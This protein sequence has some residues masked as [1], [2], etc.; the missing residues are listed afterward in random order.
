MANCLPSP[1]SSRSLITST[2]SKH[3]IPT[4]SCE[5]CGKLKKLHSR[6]ISLCD[7]CYARKWRRDHPEEIKAS[8]AASYARNRE[9]RQVEARANYWSHREQRLSY[10][11]AYGAAHR[12]EKSESNR[13]YRLGH[14]EELATYQQSYRLQH[15]FSITTDEYDALLEKQGSVCAI[16]RRPERSKSRSGG[17]RRLGVDHDHE[18]GRVRGLLCHGCNTSL[19]MLEQREWVAAAEAYLLALSD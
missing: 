18:T 8:R 17:V 11:S 5:D 3:Q 12:E 2:G 4:V 15:R 14:E 1:T 9:K 16:C 10:A 13:K 6:A 19:G 7:N